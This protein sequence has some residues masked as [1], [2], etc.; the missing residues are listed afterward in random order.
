M[1]SRG[2]WFGLLRSAFCPQW[3]DHHIRCISEEGLNPSLYYLGLEWPQVDSFPHRNQLINAPLWGSPTGTFNQHL[4]PLRSGDGHAQL[5]GKQSCHP[6]SGPWHGETIY[7]ALSD[8][9]DHT[10]YNADPYNQRDP[11]FFITCQIFSVCVWGGGLKTETGKFLLHFQNSKSS[12]RC[13]SVSV[14]T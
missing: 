9:I 2:K 13:W 5:A 8:K 4:C 14:P 10:A 12:N 3:G 1:E 11:A 7:L 6:H